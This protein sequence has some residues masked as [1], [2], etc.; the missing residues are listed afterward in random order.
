MD[1][2]TISHDSMILLTSFLP[3][4]MKNLCGLLLLTTALCASTWVLGKHSRVKRVGKSRLRTLFTRE[5][6]TRWELDKLSQEWYLKVVF[7]LF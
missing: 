6:P 7:F 4:N 1:S 3:M 2:K 5:T